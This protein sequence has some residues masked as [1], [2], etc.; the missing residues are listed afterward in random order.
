MKFEFGDRVECFNTDSILDGERGTIIGI[1]AP[2]VG[3]FIYIVHM[4]KHQA[5]ELMGKCTGIALTEHCLKC[6]GE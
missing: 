5:N 4:D 3:A 6:V 2:L 1:A